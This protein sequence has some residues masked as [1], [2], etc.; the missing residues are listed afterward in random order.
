MLTLLASFR[1]PHSLAL[2]NIAPRHQLEVLQ[3]NAKRPR[4]KPSD[5]ILWTRL[6]R[7]LPNWHRHLLIVQPDTVIRRHRA[8]WRLFWR[9]RSRPE[10]GRPKAT[11]EVHALIRQMSL[12]NRLWGSPRIHGELIKLGYDICESTIAKYMIRRP[13]RPSQTWLTFIRNHMAEIAAI[14]VKQIVTAYRSI[15]GADGLNGRDRGLRPN[16]L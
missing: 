8:G 9:W 14:D 15:F 11:A 3:R 5:R 16:Q 7:F 12:D 13:N 10:K 1:T 4:L 2:E 6:V